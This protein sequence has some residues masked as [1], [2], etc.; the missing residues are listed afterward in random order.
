MEK[1]FEVISCLA[2]ASL[3]PENL[4]TAPGFTAFANKSKV[5]VVNSRQKPTL[6]E[7]PGTVSLVKHV[8]LEFQDCLVVG[9][10]NGHL[11]IYCKEH[12]KGLHT[13]Q[14][15]ETDAEPVYFHGCDTDGKSLLFLG[16]SLGICVYVVREDTIKE[17]PTISTKLHVISVAYD[18][19]RLYAGDEGGSVHIYQQQG[20][21]PNSFGRL[22]KIEGKGFP[23]NSIKVL[24]GGKTVVCGY[25]NGTISLIDVKSKTP[26]MTMKAHCSP[27]MAIAAHPSKVQ[28]A[29]VG[30]DSYLNVWNYNEKMNK[31]TVVNSL[32]MAKK[33]A[34]GVS[35]CEDGDI[36]ATFFDD[37]NIYKFYG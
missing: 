17:L 21:T 26:V 1:N 3:I 5:V 10:F 15:K 14:K 32:S 36:T 20:I 27:V 31:V 8:K 22:A 33:F 2:S 19:G 25:D 12:K 13:I 24:K 18:N 37:P 23:C 16:G 28:F 30:E 34:V 4:T 9:T 11:C 7:E 6:F 35:Y 29:S